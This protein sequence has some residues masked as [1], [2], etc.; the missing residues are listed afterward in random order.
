MGES[1]CDVTF[2]PEHEAGG[3]A[4]SLANPGVEVFPIFY[5]SVISVYEHSHPRSILPEFHV[6]YALVTS[7]KIMY[8]NAPAERRCF[9]IRYFE[10]GINVNLNGILRGLKKR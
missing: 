3:R 8:F 1:T 4:L 7:V 5:C 9:Q 10:V 6:T 2:A